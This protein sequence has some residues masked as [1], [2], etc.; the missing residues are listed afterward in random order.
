M[1]APSNGTGPTGTEVAWEL[2]V[3]VVVSV[4][5]PRDRAAWGGGAVVDSPGDV[6]PCRCTRWS[7][8]MDR[9]LRR[10]VWVLLGGREKPVS[11]SIPKKQWVCGHL[12]RHQLTVFST[13]P[14]WLVS[15]KGPDPF[16]S[17]CSEHWEA[18]PGLTW[19]KGRC[20]SFLVERKGPEGEGTA[21][22][23]QRM[24]PW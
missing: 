23:H 20:T 3:G 24:A 11:E 8:A 15:T 17:D 1:P 21:R 12:L 18:H 14:C 9:P 22:G 4:Q 13:P 10:S 2:G 19:L 16:F 6:L 5:P 7:P